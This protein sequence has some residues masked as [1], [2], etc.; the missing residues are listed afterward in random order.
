MFNVML[1]CGQSGL[2]GTYIGLEEM[3]TLDSHGQKECYN[4]PSKPKYKWYHL[5]TLKIEG[6][7]AFLEQSPIAI[8][9]KDTL[10]SGS[11]G[12]YYYYSGAIKRT[13]ETIITISLTETS[14]DYCGELMKELSD[15]TFIR[16]YRTKQ[17]LAKIDSNGLLI[18][19][20]L[21]KKNSHST[22]D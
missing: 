14:C 3:C 4:D 7:S 10:Y 17:Y 2:N 6:D 18:N 12:G 13:T 9:N 5:T 20:Y 11:D 8:F 21:F 16:E 19:S 15:G 1:T 22:I